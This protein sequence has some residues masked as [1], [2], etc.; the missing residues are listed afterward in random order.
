MLLYVFAGLAVL[1]HKYTVVI[2]NVLLSD[3][4]IKNDEQNVVY[5][6]YFYDTFSIGHLSE[7]HYSLEM[8]NI[9][10]NNWW[11][12]IIFLT[13]K[14]IILGRMEEMIPLLKMLIIDQLMTACIINHGVSLD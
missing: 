10:I 4:K 14:K 13:L 11:F 5:F 8:Y 9:P 6:T 1:S 2:T 7:P 12:D 3:L